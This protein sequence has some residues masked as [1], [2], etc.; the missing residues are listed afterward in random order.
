MG[1]GNTGLS[2]RFRGWQQRG[3]CGE[4]N[5][6]IYDTISGGYVSYVG[7]CCVCVV[8]FF[9]ICFVSFCF[10]QAVAKR[11]PGYSLFKHIGNLGLFWSW[12]SKFGYEQFFLKNQ[13]SSSKWVP[14]GSWAW[15]PVPGCEYEGIWRREGCLKVRLLGIQTS[16]PDL[17]PGASGPLPLSPQN[18]PIFF[19]VSQ[20][21]AEL[22]NKI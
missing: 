3:L 6:I 4:Q 20:H 11:L 14:L 2:E 22:G 12:G 15:L 16:T 13:N 1:S 5:K 7:L 17:Q 8:L 18:P 21:S 19:S 10:G 9:L